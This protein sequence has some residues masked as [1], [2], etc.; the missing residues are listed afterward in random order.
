MTTA[1]ELGFSP[2]VYSLFYPETQTVIDRISRVYPHEMYTEAWTKKQDSMHD[3]FLE[4]WQLWARPSL[5]NINWAN[6]FPHSY[7]CNGSSEAIR[8]SLAQYAA[9]C[10]LLGGNGKRVPRIHV[11]EGEYEGYRAVAEGYGIKVISHHSSIS[12]RVNKQQRFC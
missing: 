10:A 11:F 7:P 3:E 4:A 5:P 1:L 8:E 6:E 2:T 9:D 12:V